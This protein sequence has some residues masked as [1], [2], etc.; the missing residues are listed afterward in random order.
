M[1][2]PSPLTSLPSDLLSEILIP[3]SQDL[4]AG[5]LIALLSLS[6]AF[7]AVLGTPSARNKGVGGWRKV[8]DKLDPCAAL[9]TDL[10]MRGCSGYLEHAIQLAGGAEV[11]EPGFILL[12]RALASTICECGETTRYVAWSD[13][14]G[15]QRCCS[16]CSLDDES[17]KHQVVLLNSLLFEPSPSVIIDADALPH[18]AALIQLTCAV[19]DASDGD[20]I[21]LRGHF[22][23]DGAMEGGT[24][25]EGLPLLGTFSCSTAVRLLGLPAL[26]AAPAGAEGVPIASGIGTT[27]ANQRL[28]VAALGPRPY[29]AISVLENCLELYAPGA[30]F[31]KLCISSGQYHDFDAESHFAGIYLIA[32]EDA[33][34]SPSLIL[35]RCWLQG[36]QGSCIVAGDGARC[37]LLNSVCEKADGMYFHAKS[38]VTLRVSG[39]HFYDANVSTRSLQGVQCDATVEAVAAVNVFEG[40]VSAPRG[41]ILDENARAPVRTRLLI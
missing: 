11:Q 20:T 16:D 5:G 34:V 14:V 6:P 23:F 18:A 25:A 1:E 36:L 17:E 19:M 2:A 33:T 30:L 35:K 21:G 24:E 38:G 13:T 39:S 4:D 41:D 32:S 27:G 28:A 9:V 15:L 40:I 3:L 37:A 26:N 8:F 10:N 12:A 29:S 31:E 22:D 7:R